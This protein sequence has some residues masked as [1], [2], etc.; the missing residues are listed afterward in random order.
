MVLV[1][2][3][4]AFVI[5]NESKLRDIPKRRYPNFT[6]FAP[7]FSP[8]NA[9]KVN[10]NPYLQARLNRGRGAGGAIAP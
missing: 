7:S 2:K 4:F 8:Q 3:V 9:I 5:L 6:F 10:K 1:V